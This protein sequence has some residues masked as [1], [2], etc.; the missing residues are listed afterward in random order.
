VTSA[1]AKEAT[2][3]ARRTHL[4]APPPVA[5]PSPTPPAGIWSQLPPAR[6][7]RLQRLLAELLS[8]PVLTEAAPPREG[9]HD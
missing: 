1:V 6:R 8:R 7:Q 9:C 4:R 3:A 2:H 5:L